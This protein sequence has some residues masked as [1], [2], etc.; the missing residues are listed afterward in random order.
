M[1]NLLEKASILLTPTAYDDG[2]ILSVKPEE[3]LGEELV[4]NG[5][6]SDGTNGWVSRANCTLAAVNNQLKTT[7]TGS[8]VR[9][10]A[11]SAMTTTIG[12]KYV[13]SID[14]ITEPLS[15]TIIKLDI[16]SSYGS[17]NILSTPLALGA[18]K[19]Y[20]F[21]ATST[22]TYLEFSTNSGVITEF[23]TIDNVSV[24]EQTDGDFDFTRN[25][26]A[27]RVNSQGLIEDM[28]I[29]SGNLVS[30][31]DFSQE[32]AEQV[33]NGDFATDSDWVNSDINGFSI[34]GGKLNLSNVAYAKNTS[35]FNVTT[36]GKTYKVTFEISDYVKGSVRIYLGGSVTPIQSSNG[37]FTSYVTVS[38]NT[39]VGIQTLDGGGTTLSIDNV[40]VK[41]VGQD[42]ILGTGWTIEANQLVRAVAVS[43]SY[44]QTS[45]DL[46]VIGRL[47]KISINVTEVLSGTLYVYG[48]LG[49]T[50]ALTITSAGV[51]TINHIWAS[52]QPL[53]VFCSNSFVGKVSNISVIEITDDTNLPR[54]N[55][56]GFSYQD[57]LGSELVSNG[58]FS[59]G[60]NGWSAHVGSTL[61]L[62]NGMAKVTTVGSQGFIKRTDLSIETGKTY[63]CKAYIT[64]GLSPQWYINS[65]NNP[66]NLSLISE[67]TYGG[68]V[69]TTGNNSY[70]YIRGNGTSGEVS[71]IDNVSVKEVL[72]QE[73]VPD[74]G[75]GSWLFE[76]Q[77]TNLVTYSED[78]SQSG[79]VKTGNTTISAT[80]I[81]SPS[82]QNNAT[83]ITGLNGSGGNDL[84]FF[85]SGFNSA[86][87]TLSFSVYLKGSGTLR[88]QLSNGVD[89]SFPIII[90]L[91]STWERYS[92]TS[93]FNSTNTQT[94]FHCNI[95]DSGGNAT[96]YDVWGAQ[97]EQ[98]SYPTSYI[99]TNGSTVTRL[100][101]AAFGSG[102]SDLINSTEGVLYFEG[103]ALTNE[104]DVNKT[105][106]ISNVSSSNRVQL[107]LH[108]TP[109][110]I[111]FY[112]T[113]S[114]GFALSYSNFSY[115]KTEP[116]KIAVKWK[117]GDVG[118]FINGI[119]VYTGTPANT[120]LSNTLNT[121]SFADYNNV[122]SPFYGKTKCLAVFKEALTDEELE[123]LTTDE[124]SYSSFT[125][126]ALANNYTII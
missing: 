105:I 109:S 69:T 86:N 63:F 23:I 84:R 85:P 42:W 43:G 45:Y 28:Q 8:V 65:V 22:S 107:T 25:S 24:K 61:E 37:V 7:F 101:D 12:R 5:N 52:D 91:S 11:L 48:G 40:S 18:S 51:Y 47:Y 80:N 93:T 122:G 120:F 6:F 94:E 59:D 58:D 87:K 90:N 73:V 96:S 89:Q 124:T 64:N 119:K 57:S 66:V 9:A 26:S 82:G 98:L 77:S 71:Y 99:P 97:L 13:V 55:Y 116:L 53:G 56:E 4:V 49:G 32:G 121:L 2:K 38:A 41:E 78:F 54:I 68:Y 81:I 100:K 3:V 83:N 39:T 35:Q 92:L 34:S 123:C 33:T 70:F 126:L 103:S 102:N 20:Y 72:G 115:N 19:K 46:G 44:A 14:Y 27:T 16:G 1:S 108:G 50:P 75:C 112:G 31:G 36:V 15:S 67:N 118:I 88:I 60:L 29:L 30:N 114:E 111:S 106:G 110:R 79:W 10:S 76:P 117:I 21:T 17:S 62:E 125:A 95:D 74:S 113:S 104:T